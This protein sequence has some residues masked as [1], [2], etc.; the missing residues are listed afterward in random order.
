VTNTETLSTSTQQH[1]DFKPTLG[2]F[3]ATAIVMGS[4]IGSGIFLVP[5]EVIRILHTPEQLIFCFLL[6]GLITVLGAYSFS[7]LSVAFPF[8]GG[9]YVFLK[10]AWGNWMG[11]LYGWALLFVI[12]G[13]ALAAVS[14]AFS[15]FLG[16]IYPWVSEKNILMT[17]SGF[18]MSSHKLVS[19]SVLTFLTLFNCFGVEQGAKLQNIFTT[20]K[21]LAVI[22]LIVLGLTGHLWANPFSSVLMNLPVGES[23]LTPLG[24]EQLVWLIPVALVG[25]LFSSDAWYNVTFIG[26]EIKNPTHTIPKALLIGTS[27]V[28]V[29]YLLAVFAYLNI[30]PP[31]AIANAPQSRVATLMLESLFGPVGAIAM[32]AAILIS[33]FGCLN[34]MILAGARVVFAMAKDDL[35]FKTFQQ[36][37][38]K[39]LSPNKALVVQGLWAGILA[40]SGG[41][42]ALLNYI[43]FSVLLFYL[44]TVG[45]SFILAKQKKLQF[46]N[47]IQIIISVSYCLLIAYLTIFL[48]IQKPAETLPGLFIILGGIPIYWVWQYFHKN[49]KAKTSI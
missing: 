7:R 30:L 11:F 41:Y 3:S 44:F 10:E 9:Q 22:A 5:A 33:T 37:H 38:P 8:A 45:G 42:F 48:A 23:P 36:L 4:M 47:P 2:L 31:Q 19:L 12:Q 32:A 1:A 18:E 17:L 14:V 28:V 16:V 35:F 34:G 49:K 25:P 26:S 29:I 13:G 15:N 24:W 46:T 6:S 39:F 27:A 40:L 20:I 43:V 21:V